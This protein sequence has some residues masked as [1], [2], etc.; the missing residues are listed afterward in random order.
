MG[1]VVD[2]RRSALD[3]SEI[4]MQVAHVD[5]VCLPLHDCG[6]S[7]KC[8]RMAGSHSM[9]AT[10]SAASLRADRGLEAAIIRILAG[11]AVDGDRVLSRDGDAPTVGG[12]GGDASTACRRDRDVA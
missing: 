6:A 7:G 2:S 11:G 4:P 3:A 5:S 1:H 9:N 8:S 12:P 10:G